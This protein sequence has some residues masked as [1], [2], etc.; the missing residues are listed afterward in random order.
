MLGLLRKIL[1]SSMHQ[2]FQSSYLP[3]LFS[4]IHHLITLQVVQ[5]SYTGV[6]LKRQ[7]GD[8]NYKTPNLHHQII[9]RTQWI[10]A[11]FKQINLPGSSISGLGSAK[12]SYSEEIKQHH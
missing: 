2:F 8:I 6:Q 1:D 3:M 7:T 9:I 4:I 10:K 5:K 11:L 12:R